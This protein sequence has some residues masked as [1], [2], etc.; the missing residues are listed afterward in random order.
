MSEFGRIEEKNLAALNRAEQQFGAGVYMDP[1]GD[2]QANG[3]E[4]EARAIVTDE[5]PNGADFRQVPVDIRDY[6]NSPI[7]GK[8]LLMASVETGNEAMHP[9]M[10]TPKPGHPGVVRLSVLRQ[11]FVP[12][13]GVT[14]GI[15]FV[16]SLEKQT[17]APT[18]GGH[19]KTAGAFE[20]GHFGVA[21]L[22][23]VDTD[24]GRTL[25]HRLQQKGDHASHDTLEADKTGLPGQMTRNGLASSDIVPQVI[26]VAT[27]QYKP[28]Q[29]FPLYWHPS[30]ETEQGIASPAYEDAT[31]LLIGG[32]VDALGTDGLDRAKRNISNVIRGAELL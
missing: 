23:G 27:E 31:R 30:F 3:A 19:V 5:K 10:L 21:M 15:D 18:F 1:S 32:A 28:G 11:P 22:S 9:A 4:F 20:G 16:L 7:M 26:E 2:V 14:S 25:V 13:V 17:Q 12:K 29:R 8:L 6:P 24:S